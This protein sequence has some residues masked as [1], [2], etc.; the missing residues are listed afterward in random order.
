MATH[1]DQVYVLTSS[2]CH[3]Y[4]V[5]MGE[6]FTKELQEVQ[7]FLTE[8]SVKL[9]GPLIVNFESIRDPIE[10]TSVPID[11]FVTSVLKLKNQRWLLLDREQMIGYLYPTMQRIVL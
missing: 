11:I 8:D 10:Q 3:Q 7:K 4:K 9:C 5:S 2:V 6:Y 1:L